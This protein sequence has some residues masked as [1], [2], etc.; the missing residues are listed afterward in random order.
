MQKV[1]FCTFIFSKTCY[2]F[3][4]MK[5]NFQQYKNMLLSAAKNNNGSSVRGL[6]QTE[7]ISSVYNLYESLSDK[8]EIIKRAEIIAFVLDNCEFTDDRK[9]IFPCGITAAGIIDRLRFE[10]V[11]LAEQTRINVSHRISLAASTA[12]LFNG[13]FDFSHLMPDWKRVYSLGIPGLL[14]NL[15]KSEISYKKSGTLND[16]QKEYFYAGKRTLG[17]LIRYM[18]RRAEREKSYLTQEGDFVANAFYSL[19]AGKP[20]T[21]YE[22]MLLCFTFYTVLTNVEGSFVRSIGALDELYAPYYYNDIKNGIAEEDQ[23]AL[24]DCFYYKWQSMNVA[25]N[26]PFYLGGADVCGNDKITDFSR[27][28]VERYINLDIISPKIQIRCNKNTP[29]DFIKLVLDGIRCG[30]SSFVFCNDDVII[31]ALESI[32]EEKSDVADYALI[33]CYEPLAAGKEV[34]CSCNG[35]INLAKVVE[36][37]LNGGRDYFS[38]N[39]MLENVPS[40]YKNFDEFKAEVIKLALEC[41]DKAMFVISDDDFNYPLVSSSPLFSATYESSA[42]K[43]VDLYYGGAKYN[44]SSINIIGLASCVDSLTFIEKVVFDQNKLSLSELNDILKNNWRGHEKLLCEANANKQRFGNNL[45][46]PDS[47]AKEIISALTKRI[48]GAKNGRGGV[49]RTG[50]FSV[51]NYLSYG[52]RTG[53]GADG[54]R[55]GEPISKN[56]CAVS[57][58]DLSGVTALMNSVCKLDLKNAPNGAVL[59]V[60]LH[61]SAVRGDDGLNSFY[62]LVKGFFAQGGQSVHFNVFS[63][64]TLLDAQKHPEKYASLQVR[65]CGWNAYFTSLDQVEQNQFIAAAESSGTF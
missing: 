54:R 58:K 2:N 33:G 24:I 12:G 31:P 21:L 53:A 23:N 46:H 39:V 47:I 41:A 55:A 64:E 19:A 14:E 59:D 34:A 8:S 1:S 35:L 18:L 57:G 10:K 25:A 45:L 62:G 43:G 32:G 17:A 27:L 52:K 16:E 4:I 30:K 61:P 5:I 11:S 56:L 6:N 26:I 15:E 40:S 7:P 38:G 65:V 50:L 37:A 60:I 28:L 29:E 13:W 42:I 44:N 49:F 51:D 48:N 9:D 63:A 3:V 36:A 22:A 20:K